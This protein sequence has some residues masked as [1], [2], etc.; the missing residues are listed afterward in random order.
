[1]SKKSCPIFIV[2][3]PSKNGQDFSDIQYFTFL[4]FVV[5]TPFACTVSGAVAAP[6]VPRAAGTLTKR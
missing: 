5:D 6:S 2:F 3:L 4:P 1:M